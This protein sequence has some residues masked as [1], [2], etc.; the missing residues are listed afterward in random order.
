[1][2]SR[3]PSSTTISSQSL[4]VCASTDLTVSAMCGAALWVTMSTLIAGAAVVTTT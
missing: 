1:V 4:K 3:D 2:A